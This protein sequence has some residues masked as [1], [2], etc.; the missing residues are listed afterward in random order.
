MHAM[1]GYYRNQKIHVVVA[2]KRCFQDTQIYV[3]EIGGKI[4]VALGGESCQNTLL[5]EQP[6]R[7]IYIATRSQIRRRLYVLQV[8]EACNSCFS[9]ASWSR[10]M[11]IA[12]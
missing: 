5:I 11:S 6:T 1:I 2:A 10:A 4:L 8:V 3:H 7:S 9:C 12:G